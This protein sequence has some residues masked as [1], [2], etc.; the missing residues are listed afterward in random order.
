M[1][2]AR[3]RFASCNDKTKYSKAQCTGTYLKQL[4]ERPCTWEGKL[5]LDYRLEL[6]QARK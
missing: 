5:A 3:T 6:A 4:P 1:Y 2:G